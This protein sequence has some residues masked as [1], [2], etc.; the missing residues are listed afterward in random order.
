MS[1]L[2]LMQLRIPTG[3][4]VTYNKFYDVDPISQADSDFIENWGYFTEDLL[5]IVKIGIKNGAWYVPD[6]ENRL[7]FDLG[8]YPDSSIDGHY[9][10]EVVDGEWNV[11]KS[12]S[13]K[14]R[15]V[16]K[17]KLEGWLAEYGCQM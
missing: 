13:T 5:Q 6:R 11:F 8:W 3:Y 14:D 4:A 10:L 7:L 16:I 1:L 9:T 17:E 2:T 12:I 15:K